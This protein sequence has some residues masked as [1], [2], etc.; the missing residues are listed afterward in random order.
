MTR[1]LSALA[2]LSIVI[3]VIWFLPPFGTLILVQIILI[4]AFIEY[5]HLAAL[6]GAPFPR[7][8]TAVAV[9]GSSFAFS[10][11]TSAFPIVL[12]TATVLIAV[13]QLAEHPQR[14]MLTSA[15]AATFAILYL[16]IPL[17][18]LVKLRMSVGPEAVFLLLL[19]IGMSDTAQ[20]YG[21]RW[22]GRRPLSPVISPNKTIEGAVFGFVASIF[23]VW[24]AGHWWLSEITPVFR[25]V[26]G[27]TIAGFGIVGDLF[28][29]NLKRIANVKDA[30][31][32]IPGHGGIL[33]RLDSVLFAAPFYYSFIHF[34]R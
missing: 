19:T 4:V 33:D 6:A 5:S 16:A 9:L 17:G 21:G 27:G 25:I 18:T 29:S 15:S 14:S 7:V 30:S 31:Q 2:L 32:L 1:V 28:E 10:M 12:M 23:V 34:I 3:C 13:V 20:Y 11:A 24:L 22:L 26:L 8:T